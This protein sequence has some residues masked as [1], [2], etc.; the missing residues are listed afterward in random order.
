MSCLPYLET[1]VEWFGVKGQIALLPN[2][3]VEVQIHDEGNNE[4]P[5]YETKT[6]KDG[7]FK[8]DIQSKT[9]LTYTIAGPILAP[10]SEEATIKIY[11][12]GSEVSSIKAT[13]TDG[14]FNLGKIKIKEK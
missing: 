9:Y 1:S 10:P 14:Y 3:R 6:D 2:N 12:K 13:Q 11:L 4:S 5:L 8:V 7:N